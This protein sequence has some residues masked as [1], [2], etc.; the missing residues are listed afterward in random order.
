VRVDGRLSGTGEAEQEEGADDGEADAER[1]THGVLHKGRHYAHS[2]L[3][4]ES[5][6]GLS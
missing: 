6:F 1:N 5:D 3:N 2:S 4:L